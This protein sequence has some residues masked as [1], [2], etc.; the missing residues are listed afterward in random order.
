MSEC[1]FDE[2]FKSN[3]ITLLEMYIVLRARTECES[4]PTYAN[5]SLFD[6]PG[7]GGATIEDWV[8]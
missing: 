8:G 6:P 7:R 2:F 3:N 5:L 4:D 1:L